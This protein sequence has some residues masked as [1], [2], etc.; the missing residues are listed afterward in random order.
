MSALWISYVRTVDLLCPHFDGL[1]PLAVFDLAVDFFVCADGDVALFIGLHSFAVE[2]FDADVY[3]CFPD[4][5]YG[6][7]GGFLF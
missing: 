4:W 5:V 1:A 2:V 3:C 7:L 6:D